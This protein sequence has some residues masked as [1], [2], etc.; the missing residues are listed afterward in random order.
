M[1]VETDTRPRKLPAL[2]LV[3]PHGLKLAS[4]NDYKPVSHNVAQ[5]SPKKQTYQQERHVLSLYRHFEIA[6]ISLN[7]ARKNHKIN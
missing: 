5:A 4:D 1:Y 7:Q 3:R 2:N 6:W